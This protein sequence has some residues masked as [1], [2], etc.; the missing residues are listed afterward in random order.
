MSREILRQ[1]IEDFSPEKFIKFFRI[2][3]PNFKPLEI[4]LGIENEDFSLSKKIGEIQFKDN[5]IISA[6]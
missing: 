4:N 5:N 6:H 2:K 3:N 1:I